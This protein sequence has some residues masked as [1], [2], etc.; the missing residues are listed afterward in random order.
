[1]W[2]ERHIWWGSK[3]WPLNIRKHLKS[4]LLEDWI[5]N[6]PVF[7]GPGCSYGQDNSKTGPIK[8]L[9]FLSGFHM[10][11]DKMAVICQDFKWFGFRISGPFEITTIFKPTSFWP[12]EIQTSSDFRSTFHKY[13]KRKGRQTKEFTLRNM[14]K[15]HQFLFQSFLF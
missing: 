5:S 8:I 3:I 1:M 6:G 11:F 9:T 7:K 14:A 2:V 13:R 12:F 4:R 10:V 15:I